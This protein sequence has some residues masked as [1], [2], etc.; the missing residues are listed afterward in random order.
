MAHIKYEK[1]EKN[2]DISRAELDKTKEIKNYKRQQC[3]AARDSYRASVEL[4]NSAKNEHYQTKLPEL[5]ESMRLL[6]VVRISD[7]KKCML[8]SVEVEK[9]VMKFREM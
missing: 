1:A 9:N 6:E 7:I 5:L 4:F 3:L 8:K 2:M